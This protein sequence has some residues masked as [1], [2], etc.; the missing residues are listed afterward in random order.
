MKKSALS[1]HEKAVT[2]V[3]KQADRALDKFRKTELDVQEA[4]EE[5]HGVVRAIDAEMDKLAALRIKTQKQIGTNDG[6]L[7][8]IGS[9]LG[10]EN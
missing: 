1:V 6:V 8:N 5:L 4:N 3:Q 9:L 7:K 10:K 2:R